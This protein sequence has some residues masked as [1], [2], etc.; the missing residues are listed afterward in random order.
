MIASPSAR[1]FASHLYGLSNTAPKIAWY[2]G[3][4]SERR[5]H[6]QAEAAV[7]T[8]AKGYHDRIV[9][10]AKKRAK[11]IA[12]EGRKLVGRCAGSY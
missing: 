3:D 5:A 9:D 8:T 6:A 11:E 7:K 2:D 12:K 10:A 4:L 1:S